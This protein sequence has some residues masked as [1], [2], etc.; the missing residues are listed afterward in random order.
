MID[1]IE[2]N[3]TAG[4][5]DHFFGG[6]GSESKVECFLPTASPTLKPFQEGGSFWT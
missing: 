4:V 2:K 1:V 3:T 5:F 6:I